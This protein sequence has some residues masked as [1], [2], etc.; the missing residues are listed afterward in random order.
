MKKKMFLP[1]LIL[2]AIVAVLLSACYED[3]AAAPIAND[4]T[5]FE[6]ISESPDHTILEDLL[7]SFGLDED[8]NSGLFTVFAPTDAAFGNIDT[9]SLTDSQVKNIL[10]NHVV[11][12]AA[13][14]S[15]L[16]S[17]YLNTLA[18]ESLSGAENN[19]SLYVNVGTDIT[20]NGQSVV[21]GPDNLASNG[22]VHIV[23]EVITIPNVTSF[24]TADPTFGILVEALT[25][26]GQPDFVATL[27]SFEAPAPFTVFAPTNDAFVTALTELGVESLTDIAPSVLTSVLNTHVI[28]NANITSAELES[29]TVETLGETFELDAENATI[30]DQNGRTIS[31]ILTDVQAGNGVVHVVSSVILP[32]LNLDPLV[33]MT[34]DNDGAQAYFVSNI[35]GNENVTP[36]NTNNSPWTLTEGTRYKLTITGANSHPFELRNGNGDALLSQSNDGSFE[37]D[38]AVNFQTEGQQFDFTVTPELAAELNQYFCTIHSG[39]NGTVSVQ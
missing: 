4:P 14:S 38:S 37:G 27:S 22:V 3:D 10:L 8:L 18:V 33:Q 31:I 26:D 16:F 11:Q 2:I 1:R 39:M 36:L 12:G 5:T 32:D 24:A 9:S 25:L 35:I 7:L 23:N 21:T 6:I 13:E 28:A 19:L 15:S 30:T 34:V 20:L 29:G 17:T